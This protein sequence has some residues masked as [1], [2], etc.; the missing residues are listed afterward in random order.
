MNIVAKGN[1]LYNEAMLA[2]SNIGVVIGIRLN[3]HYD[4]LKFIP[5]SPALKSATALA[6]KKEQIFS[7]ATTAFIEFSK[8]FLKGISDD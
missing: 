3:Y 7:A 2:E 8:K 1:L 5:L 6:W 4:K